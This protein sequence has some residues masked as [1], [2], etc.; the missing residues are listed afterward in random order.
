MRILHT[1]DWHLGRTLEGRSRQTEQ[2]QF[3]DEL[4]RIANDEQIDLVLVA[5]D[6]FDTYNPSAHAE[7]LYCHAL[8][9]LTSGCQRAVVIIA[10]NHDSPDRLLAT[11]PLAR[12]RGVYKAGLPS[13]VLPM[14]GCVVSSGSGWIELAIASVPHN[15]VVSLLPYPSEA[16]LGQMLSSALEE[17][18]QRQAYSA[19]VGELFA[20]QAQAFR[21]DTVNLAMSHLFVVG[22]SACESER[23][24]EVG[25]ACSVDP[26]H[27]SPPAHYVALGHLHR[28]QAVSGA[29]TPTY[30]SG[31]P[32][33]YSFSEAG[34]SKSVYIIEAQPGEPALVKAVPLSAGIPLERWQCRGGL[35]E[36]EARLSALQ[37]RNLWL[38]IE[39]FVA[40]YPTND[41]VGHL[42]L[43][44]PGLIH[45]RCIVEGESRPS[46]TKSMAELSLPELI[47]RYYQFR[48][49]GGQPPE[50]LVTLFVSLLEEAQSEMEGV[51][52]S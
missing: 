39:I 31:S 40:R 28:P 9:S 22:G 8:D 7:A 49:G 2:E 14:G 21:S 16:R 11:S 20:R 15:A 19:A 50:E 12:R 10:G 23:P 42:R 41:E 47:T 51:A 25:G 18:Q 43:L 46:H 24:I 45:L 34:Q 38:D 52:R 36:A 30:Y 35:A 3:V 6:V 32:L 26:A 29:V 13:E 33:A 37:G 27:L 1:S 5:G 4:C 44:H 17:R 48:K